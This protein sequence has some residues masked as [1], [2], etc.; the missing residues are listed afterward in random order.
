M[1]IHP[2]LK[3]ILLL[4]TTVLTI[5][6]VIIGFFFLLDSVFPKPLVVAEMAFIIIVLPIAFFRSGLRFTTICFDEKGFSFYD[7][8]GK[9]D[10]CPWESIERVEHYFEDVDLFAMR[11]KHRANSGK[12]RSVILVYTKDRHFTPEM[13]EGHIIKT[14]DRKGRRIYPNAR[15]SF[16]AWVF[17][18]LDKYK[19]VECLEKYRSDLV[20]ERHNSTI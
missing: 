14:R 8:F 5:S 17:T 9:I 12:D 7:V 3:C 18:D 20:I 10:F 2:Q 1:K 15:K 13:I 6:S 4:V 19:L 11:G 16:V